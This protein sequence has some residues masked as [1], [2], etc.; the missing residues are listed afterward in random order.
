M[1]FGSPTRNSFIALDFSGNAVFVVNERKPELLAEETIIREPVVQLVVVR[2]GVPV[3]VPGENVFLAIKL[4]ERPHIIVNSGL[5]QACPETAIVFGVV[6]Q[7]CGPRRHHRHQVGIIQASQKIRW[8]LLKIT[9]LAV[10]VGLN[11]GSQRRKTSH[12]IGRLHP[13]IQ[14]A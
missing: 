5:H 8:Q 2:A 7:E 6:G 14:R 12:R 3:L 9:Q 1:S 10:S 4:E 11:L 13:L